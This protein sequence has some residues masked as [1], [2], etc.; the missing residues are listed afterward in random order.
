MAAAGE[1]Q[2]GDP[3]QPDTKMGPMASG[4]AR[5]D[6][7]NQIADAVEKGA[8][9]HLGGHFQKGPGF[10]YPT[11]VLS[12]ITPDMRAY[13]D[14]HFGP[15]AMLYTRSIL[16]TRLSTWPTTRCTALAASFSAIIPNRQDTSR[17]SS[18]SAWL[19]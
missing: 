10:Y 4:A 16:W 9:V 2:V 11:T 17:T 14:W 6:L 5:A 7:A 3:T 18:K 13:G 15:V 8:K 12:D 19:R 1:W